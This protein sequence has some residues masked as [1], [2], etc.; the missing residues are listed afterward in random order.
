MPDDAKTNERERRTE[1]PVTTSPPAERQR[2]A[3]HRERELRK[4]LRA[5][6]SGKSP[7]TYSESEALTDALSGL[8]DLLG[9]VRSSEHPDALRLLDGL[10]AVIEAVEFVHDPKRLVAA[11]NYGLGVAVVDA[12]KP[13]AR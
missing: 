13:L 6:H 11:R 8:A 10:L 2:R 9:L 7:L 1:W 5:G 12:L 4:R 3:R